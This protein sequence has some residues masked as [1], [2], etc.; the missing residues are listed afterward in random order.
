MNRLKT[1][2]IALFLGLA[3]VFMWKG[4]R[5]AY[6]RPDLWFVHTP[7]MYAPVFYNADSLNTYIY[8]AYHDTT[9]L[10]A[11]TVAGM[12]AFNLRYF[13]K[14]AYDSLPAIPQE[15]AEVMLLYA[16]KNGFAPA[17]NLIHYLDQQGLWTRTLPYNPPTIFAA[18]PSGDPNY[19][20]MK[21]EK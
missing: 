19:I 8:L 2:L 20:K 3:G 10:E 6:H 14:A 11:M 13:D 4:F 15:D 17:F 12:A 9:D 7:Q 1:C 18:D 16:A 5:D 21:M